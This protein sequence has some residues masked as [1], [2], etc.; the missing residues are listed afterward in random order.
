MKKTTKKYTELNEIQKLK[1][2]KV[3]MYQKLDSS[4]KN[5]SNITFEDDKMKYLFV[6]DKMIDL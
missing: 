3:F 4:K 1:I 2:S 6:E 5:D